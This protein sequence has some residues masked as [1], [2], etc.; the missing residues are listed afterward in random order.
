MTATLI[1]YESPNRIEQ[2]TQ[3]TLEILGNRQACLARE[4]T[5]HY[6]EFIRGDL[7]DIQAGLESK[8]VIKGECTLFIQGR[9]DSPD[10]IDDSSLKALIL[11]ELASDKR[12]TSA[13]ARRIAD[14]YHLPRKKVYDLIVAL[15]TNTGQQNNDFL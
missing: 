11:S 6:E 4:I 14:E 5:K 1:F 12:S 15:Q 7:T 8:P 3:E 9:T 13:L 10:L 2:L